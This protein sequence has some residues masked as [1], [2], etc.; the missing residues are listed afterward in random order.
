MPSMTTSGSEDR[1]SESSVMSTSSA[2][3][4]ANN[5]LPGSTITQ[6]LLQTYLI[7]DTDVRATR[8]S[9]ADSHSESSTV[10]TPQQKSGQ[11]LLAS[12]APSVDTVETPMSSAS[13]PMVSVQAIQN[14]TFLFSPS[15]A[16]GDQSL[17]KLPVPH[18]GAT[19]FSITTADARGRL[20]PQA[21]P[22]P[23]DYTSVST[24]STRRVRFSDPEEP[25]EF[26]KESP[27]QMFSRKDRQPEEIH[28]QTIQRNYSDLTDTTGLERESLVSL[29]NSHQLSVTPI[30]E[31]SVEEEPAVHNTMPFDVSIEEIEEPDDTSVVD[32]PTNW[33]NVMDNGVTPLRSGKSVSNATHSPFIRFTEAK[34]KFAVSDITKKVQPV[35]RG[36]PIRKQ[37]LS[38]GLVHSRIIAMEEKTSQSIEFPQKNRRDTTGHE[39]IAPRKAALVSRQF[40]SLSGI[41]QSSNRADSVSRSSWEPTD[42]K[43]SLGYDGDSSRASSMS[44]TVNL[45]QNTTAAP[46]KT[47]DTPT[48]T[49]DEG[50]ASVVDELPK[51]DAGAPRDSVEESDAFYVAEL[52]HAG[53]LKSTQFLPA[54]TRY[55]TSSAGSVQRKSGSSASVK[56][57]HYES[58]MDTSVDDFAAL[59]REDD[60]ESFVDEETVSTVRQMEALDAHMDA[61]LEEDNA[62]VDNA[63]VSTMD[64]FSES[65]ATVRQQRE[66]IVSGAAGST[67]SSVMGE[68]NAPLPFR[69]LPFRDSSTVRPNEQIHRTVPGALCLS[70]MQRTPMQAR[71]WRALAAAA[72]EK[73][74]RPFGKFSGKSKRKSLS[75]RNPNLLNIM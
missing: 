8:Q 70:P 52:Q 54:N 32:Y 35:K 53:H 44:A 12:P 51:S 66:T 59:L 21:R 49:W 46:G 10:M 26:N 48:I 61:D 27:P 28:V 68:E 11:F 4:K 19:P 38:G 40:S 14:A 73:E 15:Y 57:G 74:S 62:T 72:Q 20:G 34:K 71:K 29:A 16:D 58:G 67:L 30:P 55:S 69:E 13:K 7:S 2:S 33:Y 18:K 6:M 24:A 25:I 45:D 37:R 42:H 47:E 9:V 39:A 75:E 36:S 3:E 41:D 23:V 50:G 64:T 63:T 5:Y 17:L 1:P 22:D 56:T 65:V 31:E 60:E 43:T